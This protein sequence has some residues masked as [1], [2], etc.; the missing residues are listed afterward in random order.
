[1]NR[2][3][4]APASG[5]TRWMLDVEC[6]PK[7]PQASPN[8]TQGGLAPKPK[9]DFS[10]ACGK[11]VHLMF[12]RFEMILLAA[13][14]LASGCKSPVVSNAGPF[15]HFVGLDHFSNF[16]R[17]RAPGGELV[18]LS[19]EIS[20]EIAWDQLVVSWNVAAPAGTFIKLEAAAYSAGTQTKFYTLGQWS[21]DSTVFPR[22]S[23]P[24]QEDGD[25]AVDTDTLSLQQPA[26]AAQLRITLGG[27]NGALP[28]LKYLGLDFA[29]I[30][31]TPAMHPPNRAAWGK[32]ITTPEFSQHGY[33][34]GAGWCSPTSLA[35]VLARWAEVLRRPELNLTVPRVAA[36]VYDESY[37]G[38]GNWPFNTAFAGGFSGM[39]SCVTR[40]DDLSEL[41]DWIA[42]GVPVILSTRWNLLEPGRPPD[43]EGHLV[44]CI[45]FTSTGDVVVN[46]PATRLDQGESVRRIYERENV[47]RAWACSHNT[48]YLVYPEDY[49]IPRNT[50][51][52]W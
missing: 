33:P 26:T 39:R 14:L 29:N 3:E 50:F 27:T 13:A 42:A 35:M 36:A 2:A 52:H 47:S 23:M 49:R 15:S 40:L 5:A 28:K 43:S 1:M 7:P 19:P 44:V 8:R 22:T 37:E 25:G 18:W 17:A 46:D 31:V 38:T 51:G 21:A 10:A 30:R 48:V 20:S 12:R 34:G 4:D 16:V 45:G 9:L 24:N 6:F 11:N 32:I 41:E